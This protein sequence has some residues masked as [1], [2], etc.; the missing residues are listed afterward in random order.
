MDE[1]DPCAPPPEVEDHKHLLEFLGRFRAARRTGSRMAGAEGGFKTLELRC[2]DPD[3]DR[4]I[5]CELRAELRDGIPIIS[6]RRD[7]A[8]SDEGKG[9]NSE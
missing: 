1:Q 5:R 9:T 6:Y 4:W 3:T 2:L 7:P 8:L